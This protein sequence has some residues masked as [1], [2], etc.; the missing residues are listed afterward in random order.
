MSGFSS[1]EDSSNKLSQFNAGVLQMT[2]IH[3]LQ[4]NI[5]IYNQAP[6]HFNQEF[7][8]DNYKL[9][10]NALNSLYAECRPKLSEADKAYGDKFRNLII[11]LIKEKSPFVKTINEGTDRKSYSISLDWD[12][13]QSTLQA[14]EDLVREYLDKTELNSPVQKGEGYF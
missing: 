8:L 10:A 2:R 9:I 3:E 4:A 5:N 14:Y 11:K 13:I 7:Q 6:L 12:I 1:G